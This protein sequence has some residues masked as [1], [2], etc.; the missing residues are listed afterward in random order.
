M[1]KYLQHFVEHG[2]AEGR[3]AT[4]TFNLAAY[5]NRYAD[6]RAAFGS[7][8]V[9]YYMHYITNGKAEGRNAAN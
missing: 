9:S 3:Q 4:A 5:K 6:L 8:N 2:M 1:K 7:N